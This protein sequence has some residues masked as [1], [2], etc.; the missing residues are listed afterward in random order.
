LSQIN[1][2]IVA[3]ASGK[4]AKEITP[5]P[6][7]FEK[8]NKNKNVRHYGSTPLPANELHAWFDEQRKK[9]GRHD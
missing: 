6:R 1:N 7:P 8:E 2:N 4:D 9:H 5:Y 3:A